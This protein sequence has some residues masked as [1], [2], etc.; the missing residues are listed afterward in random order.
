MK[1]YIILHGHF[2]QPPRENPW[3][4]EIPI[5]PSAAPYKNWNDRISA[6]CYRANSSSRFLNHYGKIL[7]IC[8]NYE[9]LSFNFGPTLLNWLKKSENEVYKK[10][11]EADKTSCK[12][13][14]GHGNAI[15]QVYN[16]IIMPLASH[17]DAETQIIWGIED[18][19]NHFERMPEGMWLSET[20]INNDTAD[21]LIKHGIKFTILSP[22]QAEK[23]RKID[24]SKWTEVSDPSMVADR[25]FLLKRPQG[26]LV[27]FFYDNILAQGI[28]FGHYLRD[29]DDVYNKLKG[30]A[31]SGRKLI[32][33]ATDGEIYGH[34]EPFADMCLA[35]LS[36]KIIKDKQLEFTNYANYLEK[37]PPKDVVT[38]RHGEDGKGSSWSCF[39][40]V[41]RWYKDCGCS[42]G[43]QEGW[44][45]KWRT[46]LREA[47]DSLA[48]N[49]RHIFFREISN[50]SSHNP[51]EIRNNYIHVLSEKISRKDFYKKYA[52]K[53]RAISQPEFSIFFN[54]LESQKYAMFMFTSCGW[55]FA[56]LSGIEP[57]Q[58]ICYA[59]KAIE[60]CSN[61][62]SSIE[63]YLRLLNNLEK[64]KSN[65]EGNGKSITEKAIAEYKIEEKDIAFMFIIRSA[66]SKPQTEIGYYRLNYIKHKD[67][68]IWNKGELSFTDKNTEKDYV[69]KYN[70]EID[71]NFN[72]IVTLQEKDTLKDKISFIPRPVDFSETVI[73]E[74]LYRLL[75]SWK[76]DKIDF[77]MHLI[78]S[79]NLLSSA[80]FNFQ[81]NLKFLEEIANFRIEYLLS[82]KGLWEQT[83]EELDRLTAF[84]N[85][86]DIKIESS[87]NLVVSNLTA[88]LVGNIISGKTDSTQKLIDFISIIYRNNL[89]IDTTDTQ[90]RIYDYIKECKNIEHKKILADYFNIEMKNDR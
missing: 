34:H 11:V 79:Y 31:S 35:A 72:N 20:A 83:L 42:T 62:S 59:I 65:I 57:V 52:D 54:L 23:F 1:N 90:T 76:D 51:D 7:K 55:F 17:E 41:S 81:R 56:E 22:W 6:E 61:V 21:L 64:A 46:P 8:N 37:N 88:K 47:F 33:T 14:N 3:T 86:K 85:K 5:Q 67:E 75:V 53:K 45:Q 12:L 70:I 80:Q 49:L 27:I 43:G 73:P 87:I 18:F 71:R 29:A 50:F 60:E 19:K 24:D 13:N 25:P 44:N 68:N 10:I 48:I 4:G 30:V 84:I 69:F 38:L 28:S 15:A 58:N 9:Y 82:R 89:E 39:H 74:L 77:N 66:V 40:G 78:F 32:H 63:L 16:H 2:Y 26:D 36:E